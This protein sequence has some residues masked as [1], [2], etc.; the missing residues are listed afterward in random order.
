MDS[1]TRWASAMLGCAVVAALSPIGVD[2]RSPAAGDQ[3]PYPYPPYGRVIYDTSGAARLQVTPRNAE[4]YVDGYLAGTV[5]EFDGF[6]QRLRVAAGE[7]ELVF[8][9]EGY[10][11]HREKVLFRPG[12]T[13]KISHAME[14]LGPGEVN[15]PRPRPEPETA[16]EPGWRPGPPGP[17]EA[18]QPRSE[19]AG[20]GALAIRVQPADAEVLVDGEAWTGAGGAEPLVIEL[21]AGAHEIEVSKEGF[22]AYRRTVRVRRGET[23]TLNVSLSKREGH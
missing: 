20:F 9:L 2:A 8:Y 17:H 21:S 22:S 7:H 23:V 14:P 1:R 15:E 16:A 19:R 4:V 18:R 12:A 13:L 5:D 6:L 11:T 10:R 3:Y